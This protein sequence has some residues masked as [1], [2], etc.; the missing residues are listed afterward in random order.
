MVQPE[1][2][3]LIIIPFDRDEPKK[4]IVPKPESSLIEPNL[5]RLAKKNPTVEVRT[6][7]IT[8]GEDRAKCFSASGIGVVIVADGASMVEIDGKDYHGYSGITADTNSSRVKNKLEKRLLPGL[9]VAEAKEVVTM[10]ISE[11]IVEH[12]QDIQRFREF[13]DKPKTAPGLVL[14]NNAPLNGSPGN[15]TLLIGVYYEPLDDDPVWLAANLGDGYL[16][17][18]GNGRG[19]NGK[20]LSDWNMRESFVGSPDAVNFQVQAIPY[21][22][23]DRLFALSDGFDSMMSNLIRHVHPSSLRTYFQPW[24]DGQVVDLSNHLRS[25]ANKKGRKIFQDTPLPWDDDATYGFVAPK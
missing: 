16:F 14:I 22:E 18:T 4:P 15:C 11:T 9:T 23:G 8:H 12:K 17:L 7:Q 5:E 10:A 25:F 20:N 19:E 1:Q 2:P 21:V 3:K 6:I 13:R 24:I